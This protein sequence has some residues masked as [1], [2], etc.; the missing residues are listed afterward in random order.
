MVAL[1]QEVV[2]QSCGLQARVGSN[3][4]EGA[5]KPAARFETVEQGVER[6]GERE[7]WG[8]VGR[9]ATQHRRCRELQQ[10]RLIK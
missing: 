8:R 1:M 2:K 7:R 10:S 3:P 5:A 4:A 9:R 6:I